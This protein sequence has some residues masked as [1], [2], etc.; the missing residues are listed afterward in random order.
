MQKKKS[1]AEE[2]RSNGEELTR[3][4]GGRD[5]QQRRATAEEISGGAGRDPEELTSDDGGRDQ[6]QERS[7]E[8]IS[9]DGRKRSA[10]AA[11][12]LLRSAGIRP[13][14]VRLYVLTCSQLCSTGRKRRPR[15]GATAG[16]MRPE[17]PKRSAAEA[18]ETSAGPSACNL[19]TDRPEAV[20]R[21]A[22]LP[23]VKMSNF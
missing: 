17:A 1:V 8:E 7:A 16:T 10:T 21:V 2:E 18:V 9:S 19:A 12:W 15:S 13:D 4:D 22:R 14:F 11:G 20:R 23:G 3:N 5:Q 6:Q